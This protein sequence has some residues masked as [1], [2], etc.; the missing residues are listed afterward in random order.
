MKRTE[1]KLGA[2]GK[3]DWLLKM[4]TSAGTEVFYFRL[5]MAVLLFAGIGVTMGACRRGAIF[6]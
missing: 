3:G 2:C 4:K 5:L 1:V 6:E